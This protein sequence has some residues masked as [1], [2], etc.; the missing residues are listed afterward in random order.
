MH[1]PGHVTFPS[2]VTQWN[3][4]G[5][6]RVKSIIPINEHWKYQY[7]KLF[8]NQTTISVS[9]WDI[10]TPVSK[11]AKAAETS[12]WQKPHALYFYKSG[13]SV[14]M[15]SYRATAKSCSVKKDRSVSTFTNHCSFIPDHTE[16]T[17]YTFLLCL[18]TYGCHDF[19]T[20]SLF[21]HL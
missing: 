7:R 1:M 21:I 9:K 2:K 20:F 15:V 16:M 10:V 11:K 6:M 5:E 13:K 14:S 17:F 3:D 18:Y 19:M 12:I 4:P 8:R